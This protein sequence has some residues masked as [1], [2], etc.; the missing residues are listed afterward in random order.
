MKEYKE[1]FLA[2]AEEQKTLGLS[3]SHG[4]QK[5]MQE[6]AQQVKTF[7]ASLVSKN[8]TAVTE[9][10]TSIKQLT[11]GLFSIALLISFTTG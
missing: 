6:R 1:I 11:D 9:Y 4:L 8:N 2:F 5:A 10:I 7:Q 3:P